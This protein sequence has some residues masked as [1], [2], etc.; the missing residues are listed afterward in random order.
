MP[1]IKFVEGVAENMPLPDGYFDKVVA[2]ASFHHFP[3]QDKGFRRNE[4]SI[5]AR[6][7]DNNSRN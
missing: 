6:W 1:N 3:D 4:T 5:R 2:S 7:K